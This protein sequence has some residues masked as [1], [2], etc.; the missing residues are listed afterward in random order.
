MLAAARRRIVPIRHIGSNEST[1]SQCAPTDRKTNKPPQQFQHFLQIPKGK[2]FGKQGKAT[3]AS[4]GRINYFTTSP[5]TLHPL[6]QI[7]G[8]ISATGQV[9]R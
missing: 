3:S 9:Q 1:G 4:I 5:A 7:V 8:E 2:Q 6:G